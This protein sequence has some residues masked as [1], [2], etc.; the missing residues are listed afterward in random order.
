MKDS[1]FNKFVI[2]FGL[3]LVFGV[4]LDEWAHINVPE[5]ETF[6]TP[7]HG[8]LY[9]GF[10]ATF[11]FILINSIKNK[12]RGKS[13]KNSVPKGYGLSLVG[14]F[15][16]LA[17]GLGDMIWHIIFGIEESVE[18]LLSPT[19][20]GLA[21]GGVLMILGAFRNDWY[22]KN[23]QAMLTTLMSVAL[24]LGVFTFMTQFAD[25]LN[26]IY[27]SKEQ[28]T[29]NVE[30]GQTI[31][32]IGIY[33]SVAILMSLLLLTVRRWKI[34]FGGITLILTVHAILVAFMREMNGFI[35][36]AFVTGLIA[37]SFLKFK[38]IKG[39]NF[40]W[41]GFLV[42]FIFY[43]G[44][45]FV[46]EMEWGISWTVHLWTGSVVVAGL[47]GWFVSYLISFSSKLKN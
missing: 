8:V 47:I 9:S 29:E 16:F 11:L 41:F 42:P 5:L 7:W 4:F 3:W 18:A 40:H 26:H 13:W 45:F 37:D 12:L 28:I 39:R 15:I 10:V 33:L 43:L 20:M 22:S 24:V 23:K 30:H 2:V 44:Y 1:T 36:V 38:S 19:H 27:S 46:V 21:I 31:G 14:G 32:I 6:F 17:D 34:P 25:P 35:P